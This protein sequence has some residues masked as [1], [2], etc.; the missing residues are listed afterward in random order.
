METMETKLVSGVSDRDCLA[1]RDRIVGVARDQFFRHGFDRVTMEEIARELGMSKKTLYRCFPDKTEL[2]RS[3][4]RMTMEGFAS[5]VRELMR[6]R[7][8]DFVTKL[9][10]MME[11]IG[12]RLERVGPRAQH[13]LL[14]A[15]P[16]VWREVEEFRRRNIIENFGRL[17]K[18]G[19]AHGFVRTDVNRD[20][21][22]SVYL[23][24]TESIIHPGR[25][26]EF[27]IPA[28]EALEAIISVVF[29]GLLT[30]KGRKHLAAQHRLRKQ[31]GRT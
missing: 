10:G 27:G 22:V 21:L 6:N 5:P 8:L 23:S 15:A 26:S 14:R 18:D 7:K 24:A 13:E 30:P 31:K 20:I 12:E 29:E 9:H 11:I 25:L 4:V 3:I 16:E 28:P 2:I 19:V 1:I 17:V